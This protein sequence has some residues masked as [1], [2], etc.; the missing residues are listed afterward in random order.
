M[1]GSGVA[2]FALVALPDGQ[3]RRGRDRRHRLRVRAVPLR[4]R[5][6]TWSCSGRCGSRWRFSRSIAP[7]TPGSGDTGSPTGACVALQMLSSI[8]YGIFL[9]TLIALVAGVLWF[10]RDRHAPRAR[11]SP[12]SSAVVRCWPRSSAPLCDPVPARPR[13][14]RRSPGRRGR[15]L[16]RAARR[17]IWRRRR[18]TGCTGAR[19]PGDRRAGTAAVPRRD[20]RAAGRSSACC[21]AC[22]RAAR[23]FISC[24]SPLAFETSLG[25]CGYVYIFL[26]RI[27]SGVSRPS[28]AGAAGDL[29]C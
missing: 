2:M 6:C 28:R 10:A 20:S 22:L 18:R 21:C 25:F 26:S 4:A 1:A 29:A 27:R 23:S 19:R 14:R 5:R 7:T 17:A 13:S 16:Q 9:A 11:W 8:Y 3:P 24:C 15:R 12:P